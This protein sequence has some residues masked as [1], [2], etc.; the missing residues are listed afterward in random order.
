MLARLNQSSIQGGVTLDR[1]LGIIER[2]DA[3]WKERRGH[4]LSRGHHAAIAALAQILAS[5]FSTIRHRQSDRHRLR[6]PRLGIPCCLPDAAGHSGRLEAKSLTY[7]ETA[8]KN[9][10]PQAR[11]P[12]RSVHTHCSHTREID[13]GTLDGK[14]AIRIG[15]IKAIQALRREY[16]CVSVFV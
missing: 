13:M 3:W 16:R 12:Q 2:L 6:N 14:V 1:L 10:P 4:A 7:C 15:A 5:G 11:L 9:V 8:S